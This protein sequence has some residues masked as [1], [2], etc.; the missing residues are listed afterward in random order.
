M[1]GVFRRSTSWSWSQGQLESE[2][3]LELEPEPEPVSERPDRGFIHR[4]LTSTALGWR[5]WRR[6]RR[7]S[8]LGEA[9]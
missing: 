2:P 4:R 1:G 5:G 7:V 9:E 8:R 3:E 6:R